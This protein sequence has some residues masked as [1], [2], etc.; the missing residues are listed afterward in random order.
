MRKISIVVGVFIVILVLVAALNVFSEKIFINENDVMKAFEAEGY[1][2]IEIVDTKYDAVSRNNDVS[3]IMI[4]TAKAIN[5]VGKDVEVY[6]YCGS[7]LKSG[8]IIRTK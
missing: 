1:T 6:A 2:N 8:I 4:Y 7:P 3:S 5:A